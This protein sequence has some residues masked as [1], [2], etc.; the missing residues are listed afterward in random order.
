MCGFRIGFPQKPS[1]QESPLPDTSTRDAACN[2]SSIATAWIVRPMPQ[3]SGKKHSLLPNS[4]SRA[5]RSSPT[6][7]ELS[8]KKMLRLWPFSACLD[9]LCIPAL[10]SCTNVGYVYIY[11]YILYIYIYIHIYI[12]P[13]HVYQHANIRVYGVWWGAVP[14]I[15]DHTSKAA[16]GTRSQRSS[17]HASE[18]VQHTSTALRTRRRRRR[19]RRRHRRRARR[20]RHP[21]CMIRL[22]GHLPRKEACPPYKLL[23]VKNRWNPDK[24]QHGPK[25]TCGPL[26]V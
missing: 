1:R 26:V 23:W 13:A 5:L 9:S 16:E 14:D 18:L 6:D 21:R 15:S 11:I 20:R 4:A 10:Q 22:T 12:Y 24:R 25:P 19:R 2:C 8:T 17:R 7:P 3:L